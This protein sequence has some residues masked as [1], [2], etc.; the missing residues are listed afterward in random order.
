MRRGVQI[1][2][3]AVCA[4]PDGYQ[5]VSVHFLDANQTG[6]FGRKKPLNAG[7]TFVDLTPERIIQSHF[8]PGQILTAVDGH[9]HHDPH[10][11]P[12]AVTVRA[13]TVWVFMLSGLGREGT[14]KNAK[15]CGQADLF[16]FHRKR[17]RPECRN[18]QMVFE[19]PVQVGKS[20]LSY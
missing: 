14:S 1:A 17:L 13:V 5:T 16:E 15:G 7:A 11:D 9:T 4:C 18:L 8:A 3:S 12:L 6:G 19:G 20:G 2:L 10:F